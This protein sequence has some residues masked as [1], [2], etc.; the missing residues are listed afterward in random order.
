MNYALIVILVVIVCIVFY[1]IKKYNSLVV[2]NGRVDNAF[3]QIDVQMKRRFDLIPNL[4]ETVKGAAKHES[5]TF[6]ACIRARSMYASA[7]DP[8][9]KLQANNEMT[10][11]LGGLFAVV[12]NYPELKANQNFLMLQTEL[13][14]IEEKIGFSRQFYTDT[15]MLYNNAIAMFPD[16]I[17]AGMFN[18][19]EREY[20]KI[21][22]IQ[23]EVPTVSF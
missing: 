1:V 20:I 19:R 4:V 6:E 22:D 21:D 17:I 18:F 9:Q 13:S 11:A 10:R 7:T 14:K 16:N 3:S 8:Q 15:V 12:E 23:K 2:K 5:A